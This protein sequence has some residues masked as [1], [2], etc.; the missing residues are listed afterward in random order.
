MRNLLTEK[1]FQINQTE[2][3]LMHVNYSLFLA[4]TQL[5]RLEKMKNFELRKKSSFLKRATSYCGEN[6]F[7]KLVSFLF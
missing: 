6:F 3:N 7:E 2:L 5:E 1:L 4:E